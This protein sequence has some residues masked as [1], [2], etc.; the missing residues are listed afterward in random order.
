MTG[1]YVLFTIGQSLSMG[2]TMT[3]AISSLE[4]R[5]RGDGNAIVTTVQQLS[6]AVGTAISA[7]L[8]ATFQLGLDHGSAAFAAA[9]AAGTRTA[10][11]VLL[12]L[13][14]LHNLCIRRALQTPQAARKKEPACEN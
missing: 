9:T 13:A 8:V 11:L 10:F 1:A 4:E 14:V 12:S 2:N 6:G 3:Y 5:L 7:A